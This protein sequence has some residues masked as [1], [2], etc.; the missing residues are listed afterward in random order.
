MNQYFGQMKKIAIAALMLINLGC[1]HKKKTDSSVAVD[2][3]PTRATL[4]LPFYS[5]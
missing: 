4:I 5:K 2:D 1:N 3:S